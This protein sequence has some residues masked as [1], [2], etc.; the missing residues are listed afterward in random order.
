MNFVNPQADQNRRIGMPLGGAASP[1]QNRNSYKPPQM[2]RPLEGGQYHQGQQQQQ[3]QRP[4][5]GDVTNV[6]VESGTG[7]GGDVKRQKVGNGA[8]QQ[9]AGREN[10]GTGVVMG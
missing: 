2:K 1:L 4:P 7:I 8:V 6:P 5:L 9:V 10:E 3:Q